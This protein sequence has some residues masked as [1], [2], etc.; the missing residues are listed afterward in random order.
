MDSPA[1]VQAETVPVSLGARSYDIVIGEGLLADAGALIAPHLKRPLVAIVTDENVARA[2]LPALEHSLSSSG[3]ASS[4]ITLPPGEATKSYTHLATLCDALLAAG[5]ERADRIV[6][7]GGGVIGDLTGFAAA[8]L[9]RGVG[10]V[11]IPTTLLAQVDSSVGGKT[12][13]N[14][15]H[16]KNLIGAFHQPLLVLADTR[17]LDSLPRRE[18]AAGYAEVAKY[19][20]LG[21]LQFFEWL[22]ANIERVLAGEASARIHAIKT[23]C[24]AKARIVA[25]DET[26]TGLR[27]L[28]NLGHTF[29]HA[30]EAATGYSD[31][32]LHGEAVA[33]GMVQAFRF[34][35]RL[36]ICRPQTSG[37][38]ASHLARAGLPVH[39]SAIAGSLPGPEALAAIMRQDKKARSGSLTFILARAIGD[40]FVANDVRESDVVAFLEDDMRHPW[41]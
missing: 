39:V 32:L 12:G 24:Q 8:I 1:P 4:V 33:I 26:E 22:E 31:R 14:S 21:D 34:S 37:R 11:Q 35:E 5:I 38:V 18:L 23:S 16:G 30:L 28:L 13:I 25:Q 41:Q 7:F 20:L 29:A 3:I 36:G 15:R 40:T 2:H 17:L 6:A 27:A 19:G 9:R 10:F